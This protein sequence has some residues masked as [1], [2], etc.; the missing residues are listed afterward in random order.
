M[1]LHLCDASLVH[2]VATL[3]HKDT[4]SQSAQKWP[5]SVLLGVCHDAAGIV[6]K[7]LGGFAFDLEC[8]GMSHFSLRCCWGYKYDNFVYGQVNLRNFWIYGFH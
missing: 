6:F 8:L 1:G 5:A 4:P 2:F 7:L 3:G